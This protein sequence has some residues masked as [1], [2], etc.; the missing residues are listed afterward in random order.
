MQ[1]LSQRS[2]FLRKNVRRLNVGNYFWMLKALQS[3]KHGSKNISAFIFVAT[4]LKTFWK[5]TIFYTFHSSEKYGCR[6]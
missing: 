1:K 4:F 6:N 3:F 5:T 2:T